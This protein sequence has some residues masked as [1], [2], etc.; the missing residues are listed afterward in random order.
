[1]IDELAIFADEVR[2]VAGEVG[3]EGKLDAEAGIGNV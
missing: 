3:M 2:K 1:M